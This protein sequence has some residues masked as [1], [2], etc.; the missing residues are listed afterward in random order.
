MSET[1]LLHWAKWATALGLNKSGDPES[2]R[3]NLH[4]LVCANLIETYFL[5]LMLCLEQRPCVSFSFVGYMYMNV[6]NEI[7]NT[8]NI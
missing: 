2:C 8:S 7:I 5:I 6:F 4:Q 1:E 3:L